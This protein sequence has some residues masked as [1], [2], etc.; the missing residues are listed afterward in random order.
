MF[1][2]AGVDGDGDDGGVG[3]TKELR[4]S[5]SAFFCYIEGN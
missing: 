3:V 1:A 4:S 5:P 2:V